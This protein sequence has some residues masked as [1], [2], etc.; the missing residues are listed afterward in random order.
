MS[1]ESLFLL[2]IVVFLVWYWLD[3]M[4][5]K[6]LARLAGRRR[7]K[8]LGLS[9]LDD[10]VV[11]RK[12]RLRRNSRGQVMLFRHY[13]FEFTSDSMLRSQGEVLM[14]GKRLIKEVLEAYPVPESESV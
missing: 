14:M 13:D 1:P 9:F 6:E 4:R 7:C 3:A 5:V 12:V 10:T 11:M 2:A 8:A